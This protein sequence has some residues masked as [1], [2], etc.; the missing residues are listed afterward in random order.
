MY[1]GFFF[2][3]NAKF[4]FRSIDIAIFDLSTQIQGH[5]IVL[6]LPKSWVPSGELL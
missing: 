4:I 6:P 3:F 2:F 1:T 5:R